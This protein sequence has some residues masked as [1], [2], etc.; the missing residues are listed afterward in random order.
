MLSTAREAILKMN[1]DADVQLFGQ[2][3]NPESYAICLA[4]MMIK[5]QNANNIKFQDTMIKDSFEATINT[6]EQKMRFVIMNPPFGQPW[7]GK[8]AATGVE[9]AVNNEYKK[10]F[11]GRFGAGL[12]GTGDMQLLFM[13]HAISKLDNNGKAAIITNGSPLFSGGTSSGES[14][15]RKYMIEQD[16]I[17]TIIAL[18]TDLFYNTNIGIYI[19]LFY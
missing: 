11:K 5:G 6:P 16:L 9:S 15:I 1:P 17:E 4:D 3:V 10:G 7:G 12:P 8:D 19:F 14:Q 13:Q 2:E 18:P